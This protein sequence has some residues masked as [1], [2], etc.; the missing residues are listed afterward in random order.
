MKIK[1]QLCMKDKRGCKPR[2][3]EEMTGTEEASNEGRVRQGEKSEEVRR[4]GMKF[5]ATERGHGHG[6]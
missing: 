6:Q 2:C 3:G 4:S 1:F 5:C